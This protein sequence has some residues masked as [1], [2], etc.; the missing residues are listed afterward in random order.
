MHQI[1]EAVSAART[2]EERQ[3]FDAACKEVERSPNPLQ[4]QR[5]KVTEDAFRVAVAKEMAEVS[6]APVVAHVIL[7]GFRAC[8]QHMPPKSSTMLQHFS[9]PS[10]STT[11]RNLYDSSDVFTL[12]RTSA[13]LRRSDPKGCP[14]LS[15]T[16][17]HNV[18]RPKNAH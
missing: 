5:A 13:A 3:A 15:G 8:C 10:P 2:E 16:F 1:D 14:V 11:V 4:Q 7:C 18:H 6:C 9:R 17:R 12:P